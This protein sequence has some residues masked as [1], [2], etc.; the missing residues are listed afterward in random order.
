[1][2][3]DTND[4]LMGIAR[5]RT[6]AFPLRSRQAHPRDTATSSP[7]HDDASTLPWQLA[8]RSQWHHR[9]RCLAALL[10]VLVSGCVRIAQIAS[11]MAPN[12]VTS[13]MERDT[14]RV[15]TAAASDATVATSW[16]GGEP[17]I[18]VITFV[19]PVTAARAWLAAAAKNSLAA[20][21]H[22]SPSQGSA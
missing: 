18:L 9:R 2:L 5:S 17:H 8:G 21:G 1:M 22:S 20:G 3:L 11:S 16:F 15:R 10:G 19:A 4:A 7:P 6:G 13:S 14:K 12:R